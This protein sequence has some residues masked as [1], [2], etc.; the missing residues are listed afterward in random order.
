MTIRFE[1]AASLSPAAASSRAASAPFAS[2]VPPNTVPNRRRHGVAT[3]S[4]SSG[5]GR[6]AAPLRAR[7][8]GALLA[9][10]VYGLTDAVALGAKPGLV[11]WLVLGLIAGL[12]EQTGFHPARRPT[13]P[14]AGEWA[15]M[16]ISSGAC[17]DQAVG[18]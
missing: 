15:K 8:G 17:A 2:S 16:G 18:R 1:W 3:A 7:V 4:A 10:L 13:P 6:R 5:Q 14:R 9:H 12:F 11:F